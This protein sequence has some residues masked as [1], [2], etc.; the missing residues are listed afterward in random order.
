MGME[1]HITYA[2][3]AFRNLRFDTSLSSQFDPQM[4]ATADIF[5]L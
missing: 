2:C 5:L 1:D 3:L 4:G